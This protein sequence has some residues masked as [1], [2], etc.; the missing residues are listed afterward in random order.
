MS[1]NPNRVAGTIF[2]KIDGELLDCEGEFT[3]GYGN[4]ERTSLVGSHGRVVG[5]S[6]EPKVPY[7]EGNIF[8]TG[9]ADVET[10]LSADGVTITLEQ[11]NGKTAKL[12][13]AW[14]VKE[15][16]NSTGKSV[17]P[18]RWEGEDLDEF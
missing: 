10:I 8:N 13:P 1:K 9:S 7:I 4:S 16:Q 14:Q 15:G 5:Y 6:E 17:V 11:A 18:V 3:F 2:V 12:S